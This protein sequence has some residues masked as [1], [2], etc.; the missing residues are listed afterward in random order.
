MKEALYIV[1]GAGDE[2]Q[3]QVNIIYSKICMHTDTRFCLHVCVCKEKGRLIGR[4]R[5]HG[6]TL[7]TE[8]AMVHPC[9][10]QWLKC[11][12]EKS[13]CFASI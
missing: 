6:C 13:F 11:L 1:I 12:A 2:Q 4:S 9:I 8:H 5:S 3:Q 7:M 10:F